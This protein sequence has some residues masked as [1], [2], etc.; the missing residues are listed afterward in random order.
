[1]GEI[2]GKLHGKN[3]LG[4]EFDD[5][6]CFLAEAAVLQLSDRLTPNYF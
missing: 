2:G 1:L 5:F 3:D 4:I 6:F